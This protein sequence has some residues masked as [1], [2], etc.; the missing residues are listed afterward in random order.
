M[1]NLYRRVRHIAVL[2]ALIVYNCRA[3]CPASF[4][5]ISGRC[6]KYNLGMSNRSGALTACASIGGW[7]ATLDTQAIA[8]DV[9]LE[10][11]I[12]TSTYIG[13]YKTNPCVGSGCD[14]K[15]SWESGPGQA[16][17]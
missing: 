7:L 4:M 8:A 12:V 13:L 3:A 16:P 14:G 10:L 15:Y 2:V 6:Y 17:S 5:P 1:I 11:N 9:Q